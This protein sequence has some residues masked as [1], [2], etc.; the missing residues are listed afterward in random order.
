MATSNRPLGDVYAAVAEARCGVED[1][2]K[3]RA[4]WLTADGELQRLQDVCYALG[5]GNII[6]RKEKKIQTEGRA[7]ALQ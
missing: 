3:A 7:M 2:V 6:D 5:V 1:M 4:L